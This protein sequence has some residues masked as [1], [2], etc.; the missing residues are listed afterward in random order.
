RS[1]II[2][3]GVRRFAL[4]R[5]VATAA[6]YYVGEVTDYDDLAE[7]GASLEAEAEHVRAL[8]KRVGHA[9]RSIADDQDPLPTLPEDA[10]ML[11]FAVASYV[12]LEA[13]DRQRLLISRSPRERLLDVAQVLSRALVPIELHADVHRRSKSNGHGPTVEGTA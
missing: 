8:F 6:P 5:F 2:V 9:A 12:D 10:A 3:H 4:Q 13:A 7:L 1:N 11:S